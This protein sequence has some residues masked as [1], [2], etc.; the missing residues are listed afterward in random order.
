MNDSNLFIAGEDTGEAHREEDGYLKGYC[1]TELRVEETL[2]QTKPNQNSSSC[3]SSRGNLY[4]E[5]YLL[6]FSLVSF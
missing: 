5:I 6:W 4:Y 1:C 2:L 3:K